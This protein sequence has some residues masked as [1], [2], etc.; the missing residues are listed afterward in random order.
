MVS[1]EAVAPA[2]GALTLS[3]LFTPGTVLMKQHDLRP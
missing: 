3:V 2:S 1:F